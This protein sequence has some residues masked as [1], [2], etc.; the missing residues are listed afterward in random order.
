MIKGA[1]VSDLVYV[2]RTNRYEWYSNETIT[3][4][5]RNPVPT[6]AMIA[7]I[8]TGLSQG[9]GFGDVA[10][11]NQALLTPQCKSGYCN[12]GIYQTI[13]VDCMC[14]DISAFI[15]TNDMYHYIP[16][17]SALEEP[18]LFNNQT[19]RINSTISF[20]Y[21]DKSYFPTSEEIGPLIANVFVMANMDIGRN[22]IAVEC[23]LYW[24]VWTLSSA[25]TAGSWNETFISSETNSTSEARQ[26]AIDPEKF[27]PLSIEPKQCWING[28]EYKDHTSTSTK[29][30]VDEF[31]ECIHFVGGK[32]HFSLQNWFASS[33]YGLVGAQTFDRE[34]QAWADENPYTMFLSALLGLSDIGRLA[35]DIETYI[36][37]NLATSMTTTM[38]YLP[39]GDLNGGPGSYDYPAAGVMF[40]VM[41][42]H[43][44]W[45]IMIFPVIVVLGS[46]LFTFLV[47][48]QARQHLWK[49]S[50]LPLLF[51]GLGTRERNSCGEIE[52]YV[53]MRAKARDMKVKLL[54]TADG[55][56]R[57]VQV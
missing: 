55:Q 40:D 44:H 45:P 56:V 57:F 1:P 4:K 7:A 41:R 25:T 8:H 37:D 49:K 38:R 50:N 35:G 42:F 24:A 15:E 51:H 20:L 14:Y 6:T 17:H 2:P 30:P 19:G 32:P 22:P 27:V 31:P 28:T 12:F 16:S 21:P 46:A 53:D 10:R 13:A 33:T 39:R 23:A 11:A 18:L 48:K 36:F 5:L 9:T 34:K 54:T 3:A 26:A 52:D 47:A 29:D 43:V